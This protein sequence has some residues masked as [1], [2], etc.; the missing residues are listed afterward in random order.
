MKI[1]VMLLL[2]MLMA[3]CAIVPQKPREPDDSMRIPVNLTLPPELQ[4]EG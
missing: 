4:G 3:A 1:F 2:C